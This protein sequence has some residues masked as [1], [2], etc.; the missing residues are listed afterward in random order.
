[1]KNV[2]IDQSLVGFQAVVRKQWKNK[3]FFM[4]HIIAANQHLAKYGYENSFGWTVNPIA[5]KAWEKMKSKNIKTTILRN[6]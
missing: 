4:N 1:L 6:E 2:R 5:L 3:N